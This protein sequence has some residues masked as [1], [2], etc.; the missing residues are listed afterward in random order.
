MKRKYWLTTSVMVLVVS[1]G[2][3]CS[4]FRPEQ[5]VVR[6]AEAGKALENQVIVEPKAA[7][8]AESSVEGAQASDEPAGEA[9]TDT[10]SAN[11]TGDA[12][13]STLGE[14]AQAPVVKDS[15]GNA[16]T[17]STPA[18][19]GVVD[20]GTIGK[21]QTTTVT[22]SDAVPSLITKSENAVT[23]AE[24]IELFNTLGFELD[25]L[26]RLLDSLDTIQESDLNLDEFEE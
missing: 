16:S 11:G 25:E 10:S 14:E 20:S 7:A 5:T 12:D 13:S 18:S 4:V 22:A 9:A 2:C 17:A 21:N 19:G 3:G 6:D 15:G 23:E 24:R 1:L 8:A 26:I